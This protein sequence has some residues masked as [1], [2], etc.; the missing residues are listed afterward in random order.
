[1][2]HLHR[3]VEHDIIEVDDK[4]QDTINQNCGT[5]ENSKRLPGTPQTVFCYF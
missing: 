1:M 3:G 2:A 4:I 5:V